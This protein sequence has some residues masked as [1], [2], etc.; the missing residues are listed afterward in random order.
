[1]EQ[2]VH[3]AWP[4][5]PNDVQLALF[6]NRHRWFQR[7]L[8]FVEQP[9]TTVLWSWWVKFEYI[10]VKM[11]N[12][13][14]ASHLRTLTIEWVGSPIIHHPWPWT[15]NHSLAQAWVS[16]DVCDVELSRARLK[17]ECMAWEFDCVRTSKVRHQ[18]HHPGITIDHAI[19]PCPCRSCMGNSKKCAVTPS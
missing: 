17:D 8:Y 12:T 9:P 13:L 18:R 14:L 6:E 15:R 2:T 11:R 7:W 16:V 1:M 10:S 5:R 3:D 4:V 19:Q